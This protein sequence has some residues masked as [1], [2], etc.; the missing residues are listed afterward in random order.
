MMIHTKTSR[1]FMSL[2]R[3][4]L[5][6]R[7]VD[8]RAVFPLAPQEWEQ[9]YEMAKR[10]T[11]DALVFEGVQ[12]LPE[13][14]QPARALWMPWVVRVEKISRRNEWMDRCVEKQYAFFSARGIQPVLLKGQGLARYY[15]RP[16]SRVGGD[17]DWFFRSKQEFEQAI[18]EVRE[19]GISVE[20]VAGRSAYY[21][22]EGC[23]VDMHGRLY[24]SHN[25]FVAKYLKR[26]DKEERG[27]EQRWDLNTVSVP[28]LSPVQQSVQVN[29]HILKHMLAFGVGLRQLCDAACVYAHFQKQWDGE[30]LERLYKKMKLHK[31][32]TALH[33]LLTQHLGLDEKALPFGNGETGNAD[34]ML[35]EVL[36][37][38]NFGFYDARYGGGSRPEGNVRKN[39]KKRVWHS[40]KKHLPYA[41][42]EAFFFPIVH[43]Y[44][45]IS[46]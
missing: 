8:D 42:W 5:W 17:V 4:G 20:R 12:A 34:W 29:L 27:K 30:S 43:F 35:E 15:T 14:W 31:W 32:V 22:E 39:T 44:T 33:L 38:G 23:E 41:P 46:K 6:R 3:A 24:D 11:V 40:F 26:L 9:V 19:K 28:L 36:Q 2:L 10:H 18:E 37:A 13:E 16:E 45:K 25:P 1:A 7:Q 21:I